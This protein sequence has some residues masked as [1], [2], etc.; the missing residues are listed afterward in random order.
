VI[1]NEFK[2]KGASFDELYKG[3][4]KLYNEK[5]REGILMMKILKIM[6]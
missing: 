1:W 2:A 4:M 6:K 5:K 3:V